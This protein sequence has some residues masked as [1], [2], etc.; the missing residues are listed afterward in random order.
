MKEPKIP[1]DTIL[2]HLAED[3]EK[4]QDR[5]QKASDILLGQ[6][7]TSIASTPYEIVY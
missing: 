2:Q 7:D 3:A 1:V 4:V 6:L 5:V